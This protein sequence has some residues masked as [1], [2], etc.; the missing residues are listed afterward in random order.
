MK[1]CP[2]CGELNGD[3]NERCYKCNE[4]LGKSAVTKKIC[5]KCLTTYY[6][7]ELDFCPKCHERLKDSDSVSTASYSGGSY[8]VNVPVWAYIVSF[9]LPMVGI[10]IGLIYLARG[11]DGVAKRLILFS[12]IVSVVAAFLYFMITMGAASAAYSY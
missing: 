4:Y 7:S 3:K 12:V 2:K 1:Q 8:R 5:P 11:E 10:I 9:L 6:D